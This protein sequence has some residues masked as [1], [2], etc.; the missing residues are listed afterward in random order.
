MG[1]I[2]PQTVKVR[3]STRMCKYYKEKGYE[4]KKCGDFIEVDVMDLYPGS[5][6]KIGRASCRERV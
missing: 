3:A 1:L 6:E 5:H 2:V 4:F